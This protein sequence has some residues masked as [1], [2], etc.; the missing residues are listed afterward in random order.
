[1]AVLCNVAAADADALAQRVADIRTARGRST[2]EVGVPGQRPSTFQR[3]SPPDTA[4]A[5][6]AARAGTYSSDELGV[7]WKLARRDGTRD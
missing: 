2:M 5:R 6:M 4:P 7:V 1:M 3:V